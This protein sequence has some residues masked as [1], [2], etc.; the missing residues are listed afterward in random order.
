MKITEKRSQI[1]VLGKKFSE[2]PTGVEPMIFQKYW[3]DSVTTELWE[4]C[5]E[6]GHKM[7]KG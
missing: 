1:E 6:Q 7:S 2:H 3:L 5:G 4:T